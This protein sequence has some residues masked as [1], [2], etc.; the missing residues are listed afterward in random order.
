LTTC[1]APASFAAAVARDSKSLAIGTSGRM[2]RTASAEAII[3]VERDFGGEV[4][5]RVP[6]YPG[7]ALLGVDV[8]IP[9]LDRTHT[10]RFPAYA[11]LG[12]DLPTCGEDGT[13]SRRHAD[14]AE[15]L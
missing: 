5:R 13:A 4:H 7:D 6:R 2:P 9:V 1:A 14:P 12:F 3:P 10:K 8:R 11:T 15:P